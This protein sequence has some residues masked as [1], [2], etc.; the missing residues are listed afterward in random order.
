LL[1]RNTEA[2]AGKNNDT[3][4]ADENCGRAGFDI[5]KKPQ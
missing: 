5:K 4:E 2:N 1:P 3:E